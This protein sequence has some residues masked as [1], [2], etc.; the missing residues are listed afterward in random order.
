MAASYEPIARRAA[1]RLA[2]S[3]DPSLPALTERALSD[4]RAQSE[5]RSFDGGASFALALFLLN[6]AQ[7][8]WKIYRDLR[9]DRE[10]K[11]KKEGAAVEARQVREVLVRRMR[12]S[13]EAPRALAP[14]TC[15]RVIEVVAEE[16]LAAEETP[17]PEPAL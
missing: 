2:A 6:V 14:G 9:D 13:V 10:K 7:F 1:A 8:G 3:L 17:G 5:M 16:M 12:L 11:E 15:D 4:G